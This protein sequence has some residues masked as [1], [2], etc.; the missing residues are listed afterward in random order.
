MGLLGLIKAS[1]VKRWWEKIRK[2]EEWGSMVR[3]AKAHP[4]L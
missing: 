4:R 2:R 3:E 1:L